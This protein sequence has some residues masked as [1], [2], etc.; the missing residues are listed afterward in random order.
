MGLCLMKSFITNAVRRAAVEGVTAAATVYGYCVVADYLDEK[1]NPN[2]K[3]PFHANVDA[4]LKPPFIAD[5]QNDLK[6]KGEIVNRETIHSY[7]SKPK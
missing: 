7:Q 2:P 3:Q 4:A 6:D 1:V 5:M